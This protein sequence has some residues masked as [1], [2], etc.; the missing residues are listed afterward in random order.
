MMRMAAQAAGVAGAVTP[1]EPATIEIE[2][3]VTMTVSIR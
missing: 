2:A 3:R 1:V